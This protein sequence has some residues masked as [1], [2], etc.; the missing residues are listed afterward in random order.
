MSNLL[1]SL[2]HLLD[3]FSK[4]YNFEKNGQGF[5]KIQVII[6]DKAFVTQ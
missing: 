1:E 3:V 6:L 2:C 4:W 5:K